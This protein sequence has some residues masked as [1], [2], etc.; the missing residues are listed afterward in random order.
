MLFFLGA[1][2]WLGTVLLPV[3]VTAAAGSLLVLLPEVS[4]T[5]KLKFMAGLKGLKY[6][7]LLWSWGLIQGWLQCPAH[8]EWFQTCELFTH[9]PL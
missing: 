1:S 7:S 2:G 4:D 6:I 5:L 8:T 3:R 9:G